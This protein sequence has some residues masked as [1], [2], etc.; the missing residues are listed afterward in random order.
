M[1]ANTIDAEDQQL[2]YNLQKLNT[3]LCALIDDGEPLQ[4]AGCSQGG[5]ASSTLKEMNPRVQ[6][7]AFD[8]SAPQFEFHRFGCI[9]SRLMGR[10]QIPLSDAEHQK[11]PKSNAIQYASQLQKENISLNLTKDQMKLIELFVNR[12]VLQRDIDNNFIFEIHLCSPERNCVLRLMNL[13]KSLHEHLNADFPSHQL[14]SVPSDY[15]FELP[16]KHTKPKSLNIRHQVHVVSTK[17][18]RFIGRLRRMLE[19]N[20]HFDYIKYV[21]CDQLINETAQCL[22]ILKQFTNVDMRQRNLHLVGRLANGKIFF[23]LDIWF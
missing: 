16:T 5:A 21:E 9:K 15:V 13:F 12:W 20:R 7:L 2:N 1:N 23:K 19:S 10:R 3:E 11:K 4:I 8:L 22:R 14:N 18:D 17:M 6:E